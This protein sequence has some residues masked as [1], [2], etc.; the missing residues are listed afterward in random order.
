MTFGAMR[1]LSPH[2][3]MNLFFL[4]LAPHVSLAQGRE[5]VARIA[6]RAHVGLL[7]VSLASG[8]DDLRPVRRL[9][10][11]LAGLLALAAAAALGHALITSIR[12]RRRDLSIL[13][14]LGFL[15]RQ[16]SATVAWQATTVAMIALVVGIPI[17]IAAGRWA[18]TLFARQLGVAAEPVAGWWAVLLAIPATGVVANVV[19]AIPGRAA[20]RMQP[21]AALRSE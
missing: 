15:R 11:V 9:P 3:P 13:K 10:L 16:V 4:D 1:R 18:W 7:P 5:A 19:A 14:T 12:R 21:A 2:I 20:A 8:L 17:G 6:G